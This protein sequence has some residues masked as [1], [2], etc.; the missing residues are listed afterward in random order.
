[1]ELLTE[2]SPETSDTETTPDVFEGPEKKLEVYF[3]RGAS[4]AGFRQ[5]Q[6][7]VWSGVL[8]DAACTI[9]HKESN[10]ECDAYLL[11]ESSLFVFPERVILKTCGT[12]TLLLVL[13]KLLMMAEQIGCTLEH[14]LYGH[15]RYKFP[16]QQV[17]PHRSFE[18]EHDYL[19]RTL[20]NARASV[21]GPPDGRCWYLLYASGP[22]AKPVDAA[23]VVAEGAPTRAASSLPVGM[24]AGSTDSL[25]TLAVSDVPACP[26]S[27]GAAVLDGSDDIFEMAMEGLSEAVCAQF[28]KASHPDVGRDASEGALARAMTARSGIGG[29]LPGVQ[30]DDWAFEPCGYSMNGLKAGGLYYT[31]HIT[32]ESAFSYASFETNDPAYR[33]GR[34]VAAVLDVFQPSAAT[35]TLTTRRAAGGGAPLE[36]FR[37][38]GYERTHLETTRLGGAKAALVDGMDD[39][40][41]S[42]DGAAMSVCSINFARTVEAGTGGKKGAAGQM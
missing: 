41:A 22:S 26:M 27:P 19:E 15:L 4:D 16:E 40:V 30:V 7:E 18:Q 29:L 35:L 21:L 13:P 14:V 28:F 12:T 24:D 2:S 38:P 32:P 8:V 37:L 42:A 9:L 17:Y 20:G 39:G 25:E 34:W 31:V 36:A 3:G 23:A 10:G 6:T 11:S 1:M 5:F 33:D